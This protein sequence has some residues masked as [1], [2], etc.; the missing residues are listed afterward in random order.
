MIGRLPRVDYVVVGPVTVT[1]V[2]V[3]VVCVICTHELT[4]MPD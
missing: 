4:N 1:L 2:V 3:A